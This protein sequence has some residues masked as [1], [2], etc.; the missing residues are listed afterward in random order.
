[1]AHSLLTLQELTVTQLHEQRSVKDQT[2]FECHSTFLRPLN[3]WYLLN[4][5][6]TEVV[7]PLYAGDQADSNSRFTPALLCLRC[8]LSNQ[9]SHLP[10]WASPQTCCSAAKYN[11]VLTVYL[12][13]DSDESY[14]HIFHCNKKYVVLW[15]LTLDAVL[16]LKDKRRQRKAIW[17]DTQALR[18]QSNTTEQQRVMVLMGNVVNH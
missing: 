4:P 9:V 3:S 18:I 7:S 11:L 8:V 15:T 10:Q 14:L 6:R 12:T 16:S 2:S 13:V 5:F 17:S 1:M